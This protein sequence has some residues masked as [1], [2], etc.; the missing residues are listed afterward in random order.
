MSKKYYIELLDRFFQG[1]ATEEEN[2]VLRDWIRQPEAKDI[3]NEYY[4]KCWHLASDT[5][6][7]T[8]QN[9]IFANIID[10]IGNINTNNKEKRNNRKIAYTTMLRY[11]AIAACITIVVGI[12][13]YFFGQKNMLSADAPITMAVQNGQKADITLSDG[14]HVYINSDSKI[15]YDNSYNKTNRTLVLEGEAYFEVAK[16]KN[17]PF[18]VKANG[19]EVEAI[20]TSFNVKAHKNEKSVAVVLIEGKVKVGYD[21]KEE[22][23]NPNDRLEYNL[24]TKSAQKTELHPNTDQLLWRSKELVFYGESLEEI[25][26]TLTRMYNWNFIFK[27][28]S[29]KHYTYSGMI[30]NNS[31]D[32]VMEFISQ[33]T[34]IKYEV[35]PSENTIIIYKK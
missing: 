30:K 22:Y 13:A 1:L 17:N 3:F 27:S 7:R 26:K 6:D 10:E 34:P 16:D 25:C 21:N 20:G 23:L 8:I 18:I 31:L 12:G 33:T 2:D 32:N 29:I 9:D 19:I 15:T 28:E 11:A 24:L 5:M 35:I 4:R 14:T